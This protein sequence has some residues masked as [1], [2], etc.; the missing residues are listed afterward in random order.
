MELT[1]VCVLY[2]RGVRTG[3]PEALHQLV[4][5]LRACGVPAGLAPYPNTASRE[6]VKEYQRYDAPEVA[7]PRDLP[8]EVVIGPEVYLQDLSSLRRA[9][10][11]CWWLSIDNNRLFRT[12]LYYRAWRQGLADPPGLRDIRALGTF[13]R[14]STRPWRHDL[15]RM[16][17]LSQSRYAQAFLQERVQISASM[18]SDYIAGWSGE[19]TSTATLSSR[20]RPRIAFNPA[21]GRRVN[22]RVQAR[23]DPRIIW[24]P[25]AGLTPTQVRDH[26]AAADVYLDLGAQPGKDRMPREAAL[27][28]AV[29]IVARRG[30][31]AFDAD[32]PIPEAHKVAITGDVVDNALSV[33]GGVLRDPESAFAAQAGYRDHIAHQE[34]IFRREV[35]ALALRLGSS[36]S[37]GRK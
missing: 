35:A 36:P 11:F 4:D 9:R 5:A 18:L 20:G 3:G 19:G 13:V 7:G 6:R 17:H 27:S 2:P 26:L 12:E 25:I 37:E 24:D 23:S 30:S 31:G 28:G 16:E 14:R 22:A 15:R 21:K 1:R 32:T 34:E 33:I 29:T 8:G 10:S